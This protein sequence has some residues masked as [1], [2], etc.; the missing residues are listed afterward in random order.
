MTLHGIQIKRWVGTPSFLLVVDPDGSATWIG[1]KNAAR[2]LVDEIW[3]DRRITAQIVDVRY[4][5]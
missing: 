1:S 2:R 5:S 4:F 3:N